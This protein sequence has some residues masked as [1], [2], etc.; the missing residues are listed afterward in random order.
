MVFCAEAAIECRDARY[1]APLFDHLAP[2]ADQWSS[3]SINFPRPH[4]PL[5]SVD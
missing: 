1:A 2:W 4:Q 5:L 3:T